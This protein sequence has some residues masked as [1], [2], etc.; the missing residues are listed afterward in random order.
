MIF[1]D[2]ESK[3]AFLFILDAKIV[4]FLIFLLFWKFGL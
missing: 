2:K 1:Y 3:C 4:L